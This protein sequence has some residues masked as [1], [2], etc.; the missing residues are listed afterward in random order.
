[1]ALF[2][3]GKKKG[4]PIVMN[5]ESFL[6]NFRGSLQ[7]LLLCLSR[8][9]RPSHCLLVQNK[10]CRSPRMQPYM[11]DAA[12]RVPTT[13]H[14]VC[15]VDFVCC[16]GGMAQTDGEVCSVCCGRGTMVRFVLS[17]ADAAR[18]VP[19]VRY[20][21]GEVRRGRYGTDERGGLFR[22]LRTRHA[23]SL[24]RGMVMV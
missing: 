14:H 16:G 6:S 4:C 2:L 13:M 10:Q 12:R 17:A 7:Y 21:D 5:P 24:R 18:R 19:T 22:L 3:N 15:F 1:M 11:A 8:Y 23:A 9:S 20:G